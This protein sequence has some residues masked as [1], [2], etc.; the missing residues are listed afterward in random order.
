MPEGSVILGDSIFPLKT[1]LMKPYSRRNCSGPR[2]V[3][4][5]RLLR[6]RR[7]VENAFGILTWRF[8]VFKSAIELKVGTADDVVL[9][10]C[11][12]HN[13]LQSRSADYIT[14]NSVDQEDMNGEMIP[15]QWR[16]HVAGTL[17]GISAQGSNN[18][19]RPA[20][21]VRT[22]YREYFWVRGAIPQQWIATGL[23]PGSGEGDDEECSDDE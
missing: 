12:L 19:E 11:S 2:T 21:Q 4:N 13:W 6:A 14:Q 7:V 3:F 1:W 8:R 23:T 5:Y 18:Y 22:T 17:A 16:E 15:G 10:A 20:E 9:A